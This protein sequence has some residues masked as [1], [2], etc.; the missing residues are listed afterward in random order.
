M[1]S[2]E[3]KHFGWQGI[4]L[5][6]PADW[7][8]GKIEGDRTKG[9]VRIDDEE[10]VRLE[11]KW[12]APKKGVY[13]LPAELAR[14]I[15]EFEKQAKKAR[16]EAVVRRSVKIAQLRER[17]WECFYLKSDFPSYNLLTCCHDCGRT[18]LLRAVFR[19][20]EPGKEIAARIFES[21]RDHT[22]SCRDHW[23]VFGL[24][25]AVP[26]SFALERSS[27]KTGEIR[28]LFSRKKE[29]VEAIRVSLGE[30]QLREAPLEE[31]FAKFYRKEL[32]PFSWEREDAEIHGHSGCAIQGRRRLGRRF[33]DLLNSRPLK[34]KVWYCKATDK[35]FILRTLLNRHSDDV[36]DEICES[37][38]CH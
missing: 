28:L 4:E 5:E 30:F 20:G 9:Y 37:F 27:L 24:S 31:W 15:K 38:R 36:S 34:C 11:A 10:M 19:D 17:D 14:Q 8:L 26:T 13:D 1:A 12:D 25:V 3:W 2:A 35:L 23:D 32:D 18:A 33:A 6:M 22:E 7:S 21:L 29:Q 16:R